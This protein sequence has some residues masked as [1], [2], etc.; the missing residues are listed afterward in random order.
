MTTASFGDIHNSTYNWTNPAASGKAINV[1]TELYN[2]T[3]GSRDQAGQAL[4][5]TVPTVANG[6]V[7]VSTA[8]KLDVYGLLPR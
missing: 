1:A 4:K 7:S 2:S 5:F 3:P 6:G 8:T